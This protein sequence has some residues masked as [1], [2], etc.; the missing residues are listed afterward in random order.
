MKNEIRFDAP[1]AAVVKILTVGVIVLLANMSISSFVA[2]PN[3]PH[4]F[5]KLAIII[6]PLMIVACVVPFMVRGYVLRDDEL[7]IERLGWSNHVPL[8]SIVSAVA[9]PDAVRG[10]VRLFGSGGLFGFFGWFRNGRLG[11]YRA[12]GTDPKR[13]VIVKLTNRIIVVTPDDPTQFVCELDSLRRHR[14]A[15]ICPTHRQKSRHHFLLFSLGGSRLC[16][17]HPTEAMRRP[18]PAAR[19]FRPPFG[20]SSCSHG[21]ILLSNPA[22]LWRLY[23]ARIGFRSTHFCDGRESRRTTPRI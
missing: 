23:A 21:K 12:Y 19:N 18:H 20:A 10:S 2:L 1:R 3:G 5:G 16:P 15:G 22:K 8:N 14:R 6:T 11:V 7:L 13:C 17:C 4:V 9:Q